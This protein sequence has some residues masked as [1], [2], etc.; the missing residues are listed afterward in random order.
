MINLPNQAT[1]VKHSEANKSTKLYWKLMNYEL[2]SRVK[3]S[4]PESDLPDAKGKSNRT[5]II[6]FW[7]LDDSRRD[8]I[9]LDSK[10]HRD[11]SLSSYERR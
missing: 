3:E 4:N 9:S 5:K 7:I 1:S 10:K 8:Q 6:S 2:D 11:S